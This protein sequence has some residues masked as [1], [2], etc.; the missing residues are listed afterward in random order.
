M[1]IKQGVALGSGFVANNSVSDKTQ[2]KQC[3]FTATIWIESSRAIRG[4]SWR[5]FAS[6]SMKI[7]ERKFVRN[8]E[9]TLDKGLRPPM[10]VEDMS[11]FS[12]RRRDEMSAF[13]DKKIRVRIPPYDVLFDEMIHTKPKDSSILRNFSD[14][15]DVVHPWKT[16]SG[17]TRPED[18]KEREKQFAAS[19]SGSG[20]P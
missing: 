2:P 5:L 13:G 11:L 18:C 15:A 1:R 8:V 17:K 10:S 14:V 12:H 4:E 16:S 19:R 20:Y 6:E 7:L 9:I 3:L